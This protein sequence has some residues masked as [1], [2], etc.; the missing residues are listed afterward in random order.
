MMLLMQPFNISSVDV[1][2]MIVQQNDEVQQTKNLNEFAA[3]PVMDGQGWLTIFFP[4]L[5]NLFT[6]IYP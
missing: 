1:V 2:Q 4:Q 5:T 6:R 3:T